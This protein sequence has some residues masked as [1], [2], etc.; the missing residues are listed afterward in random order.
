MT[1]DELGDVLREIGWL[2]RE[3]ARRLSVRSATVADWL[4]GRRNIPPNL[5]QWLYRVRDLQAQAP[6]LP[7]NW[8]GG[9]GC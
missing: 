1:G 4:T 9:A 6:P 5:E 2:P 8:R 3:L 7:D